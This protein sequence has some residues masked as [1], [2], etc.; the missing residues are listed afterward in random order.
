MHQTATLV[1]LTAPDLD[2]PTV[3]VVGRF[4]VSV[5]PV[6]NQQQQS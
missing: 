5:A 6:R 2:G 1:H 3:I 4:V